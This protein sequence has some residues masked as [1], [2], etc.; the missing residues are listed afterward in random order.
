PLRVPQRA[1]RP[2]H[3][4]PALLPARSASRARA[5][6]RRLRRAP[7]LVDEGAVPSSPC[8]SLRSSRGEGGMYGKLVHFQKT[9]AYESAQPSKSLRMLTASSLMQA[10]PAEA[11]PLGRIAWHVPPSIAEMMARPG[12]KL[13]APRPDA[14]LPHTAKEIADGYDEIAK[15]L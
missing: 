5:R 3:P 1:R 4:P 15:S 2:R 7:G 14:P 6:S 11:R 8:G 10:V 12:L 9:W 13:A